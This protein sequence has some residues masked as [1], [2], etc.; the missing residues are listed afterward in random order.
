VPKKK[1][2]RKIF[3]LSFYVF[4]W[5]DEISTGAPFILKQNDFI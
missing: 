4:E 2:E 3:V 5:E 1:R